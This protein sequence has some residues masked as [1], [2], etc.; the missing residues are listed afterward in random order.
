VEEMQEEGWIYKEMERIFKGSNILGKAQ[1]IK[2][3]YHFFLCEVHVFLVDCLLQVRL[4]P[5]FLFCC[6]G[7]AFC[8]VVE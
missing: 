2:A 1:H 4:Y 6:I 8:E 5:F 3:K 7:I